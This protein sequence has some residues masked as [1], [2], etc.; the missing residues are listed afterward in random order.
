G[1]RYLLDRMHLDA[2]GSD[3]V[4]ATNLD[5]RPA[6][7]PERDRDVAGGHVVAQLGAE[8]H[9]Q[10][11]GRDEIPIAILADDPPAEVGLEMVMVRAGLPQVG[12]LGSAALGKR[13]DVVDLEKLV[14]GAPFDRALRIASFERLP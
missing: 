5:L 3:R 6:P 13:H 10:K 14:V 1:E 8:L 2:D 12:E 4:A 9:E 11:L 7:Q